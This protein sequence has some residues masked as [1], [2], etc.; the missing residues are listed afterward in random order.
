MLEYGK[1]EVTELIDTSTNGSHECIICHYCYFLETNFRTDRKVYNGCHDLMQRAMS[2]M[3][4][5]LFLLKEMIIEFI[6]GI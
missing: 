3:I 2:F 5:Q 4:M 1:T 6:L